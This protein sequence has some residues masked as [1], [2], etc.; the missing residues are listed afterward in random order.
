M[1]FLLYRRVQVVKSLD[2]FYFPA[3]LKESNLGTTL[4]DQKGF[5]M[6]GCR[7]GN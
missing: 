3:W 5:T 1:C 7:I 6:S 4:L 2:L